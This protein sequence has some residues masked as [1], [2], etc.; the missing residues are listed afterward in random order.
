MVVSHGKPR[1][2][3]VWIWDDGGAHG[4]FAHLQAKGR[5]LAAK[6][7]ADFRLRVRVQRDLHA[8]RRSGALAR[9]VVRRCAY[10][11]KTEHDIAC[12]KRALERGGDALRAVADVF[13]PG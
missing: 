11:A 3:V 12:G 2:T 13:R 8:N 10:A 4:K 6:A 7:A 9:M 5:C 1:N